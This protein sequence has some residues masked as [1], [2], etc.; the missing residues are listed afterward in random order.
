[1]ANTGTFNVSCSGEL[2]VELHRSGVRGIFRRAFS[3]E[4][5]QF[6]VSGMRLVTPAK[7]K[8][9]ESLILDLSLHDMRVEE[10]PGVVR[11]AT[12]AD[13]GRCYDIDFTASG[14]Q[15]GQALHGLRHIDSHVRGHAPG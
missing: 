13:S 6:S 5:V 1:M 7:L 8:V 14:A 12:A 10:L 9:G 2:K 4:C 11:S 3:G 15:R